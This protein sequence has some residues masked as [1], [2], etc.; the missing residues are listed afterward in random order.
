MKLLS[1]RWLDYVEKHKEKLDERFLTL[2]KTYDLAD[3]IFRVEEGHSDPDE[4]PRLFPSYAFEFLVSTD[5]SFKKIK[6][7][8][9]QEFMPAATENEKLLPFETYFDI[10]RSDAYALDKFFYDFGEA[11]RRDL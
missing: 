4:S 10:N 8:I 5:N 6:I 2:F 7:E 3:F 11:Q 1:E 9:S